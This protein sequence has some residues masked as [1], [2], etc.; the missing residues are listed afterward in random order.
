M[1]MKQNCTQF[2]KKKTL[3]YKETVGPSRDN[4]QRNE[5]SKNCSWNVLYERIKKIKSN[6]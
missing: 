6:F 4:S 2:Y 3:G 5:G 1:C